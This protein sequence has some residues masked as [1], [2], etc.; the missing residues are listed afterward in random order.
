MTPEE[1]IEQLGNRYN[2]IPPENATEEEL[3][4][5][6]KGRMMIR[7]KFSISFNT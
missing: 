2:C 3:K 4:Y 7:E 5:F 1:F 6:E